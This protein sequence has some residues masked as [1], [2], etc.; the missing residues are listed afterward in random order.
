[1]AATL[2]AI[3]IWMFA[4]ERVKGISK[5]KRALMK[6]IIDLEERLANIETLS[7]MEMSLAEIKETDKDA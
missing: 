3:A 6:R 5:R 4:G 1:M 7:R 2:S